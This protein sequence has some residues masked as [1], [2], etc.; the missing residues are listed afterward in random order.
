MPFDGTDFQSQSMPDTGL[1]PL[2]SK[3][4]CRN[5]LDSRLRRDGRRGYPP[6]ADRDATV[7]QL[8]LDA[9]SLIEDP[10]NWTRGTYRSLRGR[11][12][13]IGA[14]RAVA[15]SL[16]SPSPAWSAHQLLNKVARS[17][18]FNSVEAMNDKSSHAAVLAAFDEAIALAQNTAM[19]G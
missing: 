11:R 19:V 7:L 18:G 14:L 6:L 9:K 15:G 3:H 13:A 2:W 16:K 1:F 17:R 12:C 4:G 10:K 8:L 5:W